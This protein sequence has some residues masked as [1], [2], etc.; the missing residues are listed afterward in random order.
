[1]FLSSFN[2]RGGVVLH[3]DLDME[4]LFLKEDLL[5]VEYSINESAKIIVDVGW[6]GDESEQQGIF[7]I[8]VL[9][10]N[11]WDNPIYAVEFKSLDDLKIYLN[12][13][14]EF[15]ITSLQ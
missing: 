15:A 2:F 13:A 7:R 6:Y 8:F 5:Q 10:G 11:D 12:D 1:M 14:I 9:K 4:D 3:N